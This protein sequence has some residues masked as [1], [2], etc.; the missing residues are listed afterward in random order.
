MQRAILPETVPPTAGVHV[1]WHYTAGGQA[2]DPVGGDWFAV[3]PISATSVGVA[4]GDVSGHG[5]KA[6]RSM[7]EYRY[8][9]RTLAAQ[10]SSASA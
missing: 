10:G 3:V 7:A 1:G 6:V 9:L 5:L 2:S 4:I 8:G